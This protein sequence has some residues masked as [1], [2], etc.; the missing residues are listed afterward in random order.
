MYFAAFEISKFKGIDHLRIELANS[1]NGKIHTLVGLNESGKTT[2]LEA[3]NVF[4]KDENKLQE[5]LYKETTRSTDIHDYIPKSKKSNFDGEIKITAELVIEEEDRVQIKGMLKKEDF[6][7]N[8]DILNE[9]LIISKTFEFEDSDYKSTRNAW[10]VNVSGKKKSGRK[11]RNF[12]YPAPEW[13]N[14]VLCIKKLIPSISYFPTFLFEFP[15]RI[16]LEDNKEETTINKYYRTIIQDILDSLDEKLDVQKHIVKRVQEKNEAGTWFV[17]AL[18]YFQ[19]RDT[20]SQIDSVLLK[21]ET[22]ITETVFETWNQVFSSRKIKNKNISIA[23]GV[24]PDN[25]QPDEQ[26][27]YIEFNIKDGV[28]KYSITERSLGF[29]W[30]FCFFLFTRFRGFRKGDQNALFLFDEPASNL[31]SGAQM[32]L[33][34]SFPKITERG[35]S[36]IYSTHSH[37]LINPKWLEN[38]Y[39]IQNEA[40]DYESEGN[41]SSLDTKIIAHKYRSFVGLSP[42][43]LTYFQP[44]LEKL[45]YRPSAL[46]NIPDVVILEGKHD[47][48]AFKYFDEF[49]LE[50]TSNLN[51]LPGTGAGD[52]GNLISLY[53]GWGKNF[54]ILLDDDGDGKKGKSKYMDEWL[55]PDSQVFT[56]ADINANW[57]GKEL[58]DLFSVADKEKII[59]KTELGKKNT[60]KTLARFVQEKTLNAE[61]YEFDEETKNN[62]DAVISFCKKRM[63]EMQ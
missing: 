58:E 51:Y 4:G 10:H 42:D 47:Y 38:T 22:R 9:R 50:T 36:I 23:F 43:K 25:I 44:I 26:K 35:C 56:I 55:L 6:H 15:A 45:E 5:G 1:T 59:S 62:F 34:E 54:I 27:V 63:D 39:I 49:I 12:S 37:H 52:L 13:T 33:L 14:A 41:Y 46:E 3:I 40:L 18:L 57:S 7:I 19:R 8:T 11:E 30:F 17:N 16:Y 31:H 20:K 2:I 48:Y 28:S 29:R 60:K 21:I 53:L 32:Q 61:S 24:E